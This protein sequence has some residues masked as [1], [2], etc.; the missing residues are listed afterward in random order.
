M[1]IGILL[2][3]EKKEDMGVLCCVFSLRYS[4]LVF[5]LAKQIVV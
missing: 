1:R 2:T 3:I 5:F 4:F